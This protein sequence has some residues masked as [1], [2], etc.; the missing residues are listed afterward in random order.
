PHLHENQHYTPCVMRYHSTPLPV[1]INFLLFEL[2]HPDSQSV[3]GEHAI[4]SVS[5]GPGASHFVAASAVQ[6]RL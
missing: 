3:G 4:S 5:A 2:R 6:R 1:C